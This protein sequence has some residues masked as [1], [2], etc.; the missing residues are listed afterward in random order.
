MENKEVKLNFDVEKGVKVIEI[1][2]GN[3]Q[4][5]NDPIQPIVVGGP[6]TI[7]AMLEKHSYEVMP[8]TAVVV[9]KFE[10]FYKQDHSDAKSLKIVSTYR[11][12]SEF[13]DLIINDDTYRDPHE[14]AKILKFYKRY[15][16]KHDEYYSVLKA[17]KSFK[18]KVDTDFENMKDESGNK[19]FKR[20]QIVDSNTPQSFSMTLE[21]FDG[22]EIVTDI[23]IEVD[24]DTLRLTLVAVDLM[25]QVEKLV[26]R[27]KLDEVTAI[28]AINDNIPIIRD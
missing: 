12:K 15:F 2:H 16:T 26:D 25:E 7:Q 5:I 21:P 13:T 3:A 27:I 6:G 4:P 11:L 17:L 22:F 20:Y 14:L 24:P 10:V 28:N 1:R 23:D 18:A 8:T 9:G 19:K